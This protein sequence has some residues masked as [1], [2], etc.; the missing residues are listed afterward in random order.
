[1]RPELFTCELTVPECVRRNETIGVRRLSRLRIERSVA[2]NKG[3]KLLTGV[4]IS[5][6][7][8]GRQTE[9]A[10]PKRNWHSLNNRLS[11]ICQITGTMK[12]NRSSRWVS[13]SR[14]LIFLSDGTCLRVVVAQL[15]EQFFIDGD[16]PRRQRN[17]ASI[18]S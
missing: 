13:H 12:N 18:G 4:Q 7:A 17:R 15:R 5:D 16:V 10:L 2:I 14:L 9:L 1:M 11:R 6:P 8:W 3:Y